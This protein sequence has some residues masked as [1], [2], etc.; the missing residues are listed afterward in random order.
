MTIDEYN[1]LRKKHNKAD[2]K[3]PVHRESQ[4][5]RACIKWFRYQYQPYSKVLFAVPNGGTRNEIEAKIMQAEGVVPGVSDLILLVSRK[6]YSSLCLECKTDIGKQS[7]NQITWQ[8]DCEAHGNKYVIFR[9]V[10]EFMKLINWY[11]Q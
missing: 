1:K 10:D 11:L 7:K 6:G 5:Q 9:S 3:K 2:K 4:L 8:T